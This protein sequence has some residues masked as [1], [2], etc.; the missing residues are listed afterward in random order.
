MDTPHVF[1][2]DSVVAAIGSPEVERKAKISTGGYYS[3]GRKDYWIPAGLYDEV[4][5]QD[6]AAPLGR[7]GDHQFGKWL[8]EFVKKH[9]LKPT[10]T[11]T[12]TRSLSG[13]WAMPFSF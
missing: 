5:A 12:N 1:E 6:E 8:K 11:T 3:L 7:K 10:S 13:Y 9:D 4:L 2:P